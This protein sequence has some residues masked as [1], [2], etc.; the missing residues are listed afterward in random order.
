MHTDIYL[1]FTTKKRKLS[2]P[3]AAGLVLTSEAIDKLQ[4]SLIYEE[5]ETEEGENQGL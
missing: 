1:N 4:R 2:G 5:S 3:S